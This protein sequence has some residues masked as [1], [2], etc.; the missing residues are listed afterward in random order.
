LKNKIAF[1]FDRDGVLNYDKGYVYKIKDFRWL[2]G[3][4]KS[5]LFLNRHNFLVIV[6]TN[7]SGIARKYFKI[8]DLKKLHNYMNRDLSLINAK[9]NKFYY[10]PYHPSFKTYRRYKNFRK[11]NPGMI[12]AAIKYYNLKKKNCYFIGDKKSDKLAAA[13][14]KIKFYFKKKSSLFLQIKKIVKKINYK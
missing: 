14:S 1:F 2:S 5:I 4:K 13:R 6:I 9:I 7:Q 3:A 10:C 12:L 11:P 8:R